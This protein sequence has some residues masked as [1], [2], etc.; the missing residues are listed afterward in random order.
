MVLNGDFEEVGADQILNGDFSQEGSEEVTNG[1]FATDSDWGK[2]TGVTISGGSAN[3]TGLS[4][5]YLDQDCLTNG[6]SYHLTF[7]VSAYTSGI[8]TI[9]GGSGKGIPSIS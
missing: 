2:D 9:F 8:L 5:K 1:N 6:K 4:G 7:D 3:F